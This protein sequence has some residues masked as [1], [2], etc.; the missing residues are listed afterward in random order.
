MLKN[1]LLTQVRSSFVGLVY[2][3][4]NRSKTV[5]KALKTVLEAI[6]PDGNGLNIGAGRTDLHPRMKNL[7]IVNAP[8]IDYVAPVEAMP[9][10]DASIDVIVSQETLEHVSDPFTAMREIHRV[11]RPGG[12]LYLQ[13]PFTIGY[14][15]GP[16]DYWRFTREGIVRLLETVDLECIDQGITVGSATGFYRICVEFCAIMISVL[17]SKL[18]IPSKGFFSLIFYPIKLLDFLTAFSS[19]NDRIA[20]G[21]FVIARKRKAVTE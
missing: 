16:T 18:Y 5:R 17:W 12:L 1:E 3:D 11:L 6:P 20:G 8:N 2:A 7:D 13:L 21:Y 4:H 14:H 15:P 9:L 10:D 19:Q